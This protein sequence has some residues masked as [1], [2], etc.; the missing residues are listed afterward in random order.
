MRVRC[1]Y[2]EVALLPLLSDASEKSKI[3]VLL[4]RFREPVPLA[5]TS[6]M[7]LPFEGKVTFS[8]PFG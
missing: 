7:N 3:S 1:T 6:T 2:D 5:M 4:M 8:V